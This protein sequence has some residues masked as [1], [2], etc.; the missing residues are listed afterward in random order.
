M[1]IRRYKSSRFGN[2]LHIL[3]STLEKWTKTPETALEKW[4]LVAGAGFEPAT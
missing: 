2:L 4:L 1:L 3:A